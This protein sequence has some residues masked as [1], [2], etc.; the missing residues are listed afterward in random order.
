MGVIIL[1]SFIAAIFFPS[2]GVMHRVDVVGWC[3]VFN[4]KNELGSKVGIALIVFTCLLWEYPQNLLKYLILLISGVVL[5]ALSQSMTSIIITVLTLGIGL[6]LKLRLRP[7]QK[8]AVYA[9]ALIVGLSAT[10]FLQGR[11][12]SVFALIG[13]DSSLT[14]RVPLW[15]YSADAVLERPLLGSGWDA[16]WLSKGG[17]NI[18]NMVRWQAPHAHNGFLELS[19]NIGLIGMVIFMIGNFECFRRA[20]RYSKDANQP[21]RLWPLLFYS[22]MFLSNFTEAPPV[23]RHTLTFVLYCALSVAVTEAS[24]MEVIELEQEEECMPSG[25]ASDSSMI[26]ESP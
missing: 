7:A 17:D 13:R 20:V 18:R 5:L 8:V 12:D 14:G 4:H 19:L 1:A 3:G 15:Q 16:F 24:R 25:I 22:Y 26:Q 11:M 10:M 23:D 2:F 6:Y 21:C 9:L